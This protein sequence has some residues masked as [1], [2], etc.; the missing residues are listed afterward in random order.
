MTKF[1]EVIYKYNKDISLLKENITNLINEENSVNEL[2]DKG[3][4]PLYHATKMAKN[5]S[6]IIKLLVDNGAN[7]DIGKNEQTP[8]DNLVQNAATGS[9][10]I[11]DKDTK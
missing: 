3:A 6:E 4:S 11:D 9:K 2:D 7:V 1:R 5:C 10:Y 8:L